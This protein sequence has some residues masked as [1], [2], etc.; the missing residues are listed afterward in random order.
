M[1]KEEE[2]KVRAYK[3]SREKAL[4]HVPLIQNS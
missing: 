1:K 2:G 3:K 4:L